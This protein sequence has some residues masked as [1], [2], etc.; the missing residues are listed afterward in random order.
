[1]PWLELRQTPS[2][3]SPLVL[4]VRDKHQCQD[5]IEPCDPTLQEH[6]PVG[7]N[8]IYEIKTDGYRA[9]GTRL[10]IDSL[11]GFLGLVAIG[12]VELH[13]WNANVNDVERADQLVIDFDPGEGVPWEAMVEAALRM[14]NI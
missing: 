10:W 8:W 3:E 14:R 1:M 5:F 9:Q 13:P 7:D 4:R 2:D 12:A 11:D 6:A